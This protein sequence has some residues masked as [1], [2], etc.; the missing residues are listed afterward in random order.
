MI[1]CHEHT[2]IIYSLTICP[3]G[4]CLRTVYKRLFEQRHS[5]LALF[6]LKTLG[7]GGC[8]CILPTLW[9]NLV[10][11]HP[12][13][14]LNPAVCFVSLFPFSMGDYQEKQACFI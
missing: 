7:F 4:V 11:M 6:K 14:F 1:Q 2:F 5:S 3:H 10:N 8:L 12:N 9:Y 13:L